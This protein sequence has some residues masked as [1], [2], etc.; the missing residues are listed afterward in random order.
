MLDLLHFDSIFLQSEPCF[1]NRVYRIQNIQNKNH[2]N[3]YYAR[4]T[5]VKVADS[6]AG[7]K[8]HK[9]DSSS[10]IIKHPFIKFKTSSSHISKR[11][12]HLHKI[13]ITFQILTISFHLRPNVT[14]LKRPR[15]NRQPGENGS[16]AATRARPQ[17]LRPRSPA[18]PAA[19]SLRLLLL[20]PIIPLELLE[21]LAL[22]LHHVGAV[23]STLGAEPFP[24]GLGGEGDAGE[25]EPLYGAEVV[26][27]EDHLAEGDLV[28]EAV[29]R[30]VRVD[31][32]RL[33]RRRLRPL[34]R[35]PRLALLL[36]AD[37]C[38]CAT[39]H[40]ITKAHTY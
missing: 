34:R 2:N 36:L 33:A 7:C 27:A 31:G 25:M 19:A 13:E 21:E 16:L 4:G 9:R 18:E 23:A 40:Y 8:K 37:A 39:L 38:A 26:V 22:G 14:T 5:L 28:A 12:N 11:N 30:L 32:V 15:W 24:L 6:R 20:L 1:A 17:G 3:N 35:L 10:K 29:A